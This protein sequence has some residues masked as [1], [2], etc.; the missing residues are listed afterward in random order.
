MSEDFKD[1]PDHIAAELEFM[2]YLIYKEIEA[3]NRGDDNSI[4]T[5][6]ADQQSFL[7]FHLGAWVPEFGRSVLDNG[8]TTFYQDLARIT[9]GFIKDDY[10]S[11]SEVLA[12]KTSNSGE[13][14][15]FESFPGQC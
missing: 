4:F 6:L 5:C 1:A 15:E 10:Q 7:K 11:I 2:H 8:N 12:S 14:V 9:D 3:A 13:F